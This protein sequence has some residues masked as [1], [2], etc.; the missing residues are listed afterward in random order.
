MNKVKF[1]SFDI[2]ARKEGEKFWLTSVTPFS[3]ESHFKSQRKIQLQFIL[4]NLLISL[5]TGL[6]TVWIVDSVSATAG[7]A[8]VL[9]MCAYISALY[10]WKMNNVKAVKKQSSPAVDYSTIFEIREEGLIYWNTIGAVSY[11]PYSAL[12]AVERKGDHLFFRITSASAVTIEKKMFPNP[13]DFDS[14][15]SFLS[16]KKLL[17]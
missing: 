3:F 2:P 11:F 9:G 6:G 13:T 4:S 14:I 8:F 16:S 12:L 5:I 1:E 7:I 15:C 17:K 10:Y